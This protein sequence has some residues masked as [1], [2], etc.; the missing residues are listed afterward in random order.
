VF[1]QGSLKWHEGVHNTMIYAT[2]NIPNGTY[3][4]DRLANLSFGFVAVDGG[5]GYTY[6][7][8]KTGN[9]F[10]VVAGLTY[11]FT[12]PDLQYQN[13][14]DV[15]LDWGASKFV[16]KNVH[17][18]LV[19]YFFQQI[20]GDSGT[21]ARLG[22]FK[23]RVLGIGPQVGSIFPAGEGYQGYVNLK[24]Y[25][26]FATENRPDG[27]TVWATFALSPA[28]PEPSQPRRPRVVK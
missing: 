9:E 15:H 22:D 2:G 1:W 13:G 10:S 16:E 27:F 14:I 12:N 21:G 26:D 19:G 4:P 20:T 24:G 23:G 28:A 7:D 8:T 5:A 18:G 25:R 11:S 17:V 6:L 3:N